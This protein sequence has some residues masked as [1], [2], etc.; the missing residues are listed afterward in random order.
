MTKTTHKD[1]WYEGVLS[2]AAFGGFLIIL[3]LVF[4]L[5]PGVPTA[6]VDFFGDL[7]GVTYPAINGSIVLPA[8]AHPADHMAL[9][10][11][12][13]N[14]DLGIAILQVA[15]LAV[16]LAVHSR[17]GK[18]AETVGNLVFWAGAA[19]MVSTYLLAGT[20]SGWFTYWAT[21]IILAGVS[22]VIQ[23]VI[24]LAAWHSGHRY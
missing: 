3:G 11:A 18:V 21:I 19:A 5:T 4:G 24:R 15:I 12:V 14:F 7:T 20:Q 10:S 23:F 1:P 9:Y 22:L 6:I 13:F 2:A 16:R 8:P 17:V